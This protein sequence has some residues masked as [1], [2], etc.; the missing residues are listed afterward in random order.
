MYKTLKVLCMR[1]LKIFINGYKYLFLLK[2][3][4]HFFNLFAV[5]FFNLFA[6]LFF[7]LFAVLFFKKNYDKTKKNDF[8]KQK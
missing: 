6:V 8:K 4:H 3:M 7:N 5:L 2:K 1:I